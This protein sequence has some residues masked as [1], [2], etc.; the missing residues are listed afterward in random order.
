M[1]ELFGKY[2]LSTINLETNSTIRVA[3]RKRGGPITHRSLD[4]NQAL[5]AR[6][7]YLCFLFA[8]DL[9]KL[10]CFWNFMSFNHRKSC[11]CSFNLYWN[12]IISCPFTPNLS[13][14]MDNSIS[15]RFTHNL[16][17]KMLSAREIKFL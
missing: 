16:A 15:T 8:P 1:K 6:V 5:I 4:R 9:L 17:I 3:Q 13:N 12:S 14:S 2:M 7:A 11:P 10:L